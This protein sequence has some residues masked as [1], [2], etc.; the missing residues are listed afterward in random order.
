MKKTIL[1]LLLVVASSLTLLSQSVKFEF[2]SIKFKPGSSIIQP[3]SYAALDSL[4]LFLRTSGA[5]I[6]IGGHTDNVGQASFNLR[7]SQRRAEAVRQ[8]LIARHRIPAGQ[9]IAKGYGPSRP[10]ADNATEEGR[11]QNR[12][13]EITVISRIR[14]ARISFV[15]GNAFVR[16]QG[17][18][19]WEKAELGRILTVMDEVATDSTGRLE[20]TFDDGGRIK[21]KPKTNLVLERLSSGSDSEDPEIDIKLPLGRISAKVLKL[22]EGKRKYSLATPTAVAGIRGTE[23]LLETQPDKKSLLSV[24]DGE[25][26]FQ[27]RAKGSLEWPVAAGFGSYCLNGLPPEPALKLPPAPEPQQPAAGDTLFYNPDRPQNFIFSWKPV[28][29]CRTRLLLARDAELNDVVAEVVTADTSYQLAAV[30]SDRLYWQ[31]NSIDSLGL[32]GL[33]WPMRSS[34]VRRKIDP[35]KLDIIQPLP[36]K[37]IGRREVLIKGISEVRSTVSINGNQ[38]YVMP[39]GSFAWPLTLSPGENQMNITATDRAGNATVRSLTLLC[40]PFKRM[41]AGASAGAASP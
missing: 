40:S 6:E 25:V 23:F 8:F 37:T 32:E 22:L 4:S 36:G 24:W 39:D 2:S 13:V 10:K 12:R 1:T 16:K 5:K 15:Q 17:L 27:G 34:E 11:A 29:G 19:S 41:W 35:P 28:P 30:R 9:L 7:L 3:S 26:V 14:T 33:P 21:V 38:I 18:S 20:I 31:I